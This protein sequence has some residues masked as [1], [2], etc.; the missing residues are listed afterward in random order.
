MRASLKSGAGSRPGH[1]R[2]VVL[3]LQLSSILP[4][5]VPVLL[6]GVTDPLIGAVHS[7][8]S[9]VDPGFYGERS[10]ALI[11]GLP[12]IRAALPIAPKPKRTKLC[13]KDLIAELESINSQIHRM[14]FQVER[15]V[16]NLATAG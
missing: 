15:A 6:L 1:S 16:A 10:E 13:A 11:R 7:R 14:M 4:Q 3:E 9:R 2:P 5:A 12:L 8:A